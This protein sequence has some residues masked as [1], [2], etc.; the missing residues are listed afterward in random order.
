MTFDKASG[1]TSYNDV[2]FFLVFIPLANA[3]NYYL[4]YTDI[5]FSGHTLLTFSI[6]TME[7]YASWLGLRAVVVYL[8]RK[9]PYAG[10]PLRRIIVQILLTVVVGLIIIVVLTELVN[11]FARDTPVP[12]NFFLFDLF[13]FFIW[14]LV[15]NGIYIGLHYYQAMKGIERTR[16]EEARMRR[17]GFVVKDSRQ[18][19]IFP[20][21]QVAGF[22]VSGDYSTLITTEAKKIPGR[23]ING[24]HCQVVA[25]RNVLSIESAIHRSPVGCHGF[26][27]NGK[28]QDKCSPGIAAVFRRSSTRKSNQSSGLQEVVQWRMTSLIRRRRACSYQTRWLAHLAANS[29]TFHRKSVCLS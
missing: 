5:Q 24:K 19:L 8:D 11:W 6:D 18:N 12:A 10:S 1:V 2:L 4:T 22:F 17:E 23:P 15:I 21:S 29:A 14:L 28:R 16:A 3:V 26:H 13:I 27:Q 25:H 9:I 7:G 20:L